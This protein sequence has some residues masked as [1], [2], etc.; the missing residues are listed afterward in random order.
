MSDNPITNQGSAFRDSLVTQKENEVL[1]KNI[2]SANAQDASYAKMTT[3]ESED[4]SVMAQ[5]YKSLKAPKKSTDVDKVKK[6]FE[7]YTRVLARKEEADG[8]AQDFTQKYREYHLDPLLLSSLLFDELGLNIHENSS[9]NEIIQIVLRR[10]TGKAGEKVT[11]ALIFKGLEF[12]ISVAQRL[13]GNATGPEK[14]RLE[15]IIEKLEAALAAYLEENAVDIND[16][17]KIIGVVDAVVVEA[18]TDVNDTLTR[19]LDVVHSQTDIQ[20]VRKQYES[21]T[22]EKVLKEIS[23]LLKKLN[24]DIKDPNKENA[25]IAQLMKF[26]KQANAYVHV[27]Y[28]AADELKTFV[29]G[30]VKLN[31]LVSKDSKDS[32]DKDKDGKDKDNKDS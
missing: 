28:S 32:K 30:Y 3:V 23:A 4:Q 31:Q 17:D 26:A 19:Y 5:A 18:D 8:F 10:L 27:H 15:L 25:M 22:F 16:S 12:L 7:V 14:S 24:K 1:S 20:T 9:P 13:S 29:K 2:A 11:P 21:Q 6:L